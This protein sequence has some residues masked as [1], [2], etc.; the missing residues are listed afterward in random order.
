MRLIVFLLISGIFPLSLFSQSWVES[1][2]SPSDKKSSKN[3]YE[4][5]KEFNE[6]WKEYEL[7]RGYYYV[8]GE[9]RKAGGWKQFK[10]W[11]WFW[12]TRI[13]RKTG[14][15]PNINMLEKHRN[16]YINVKSKS[17][18]SNW[19]EM[20]PNSSDGGYAGIGRLNCVAFH[21]TDPNTFFV[22]AP[23]GGLWKT[24][25][26]GQSWEVLTDT[27]PVIGVSE[28][29]VPNDYDT[30][31]TLYIATGD[32][33]A[34]DNYS[35]GVL[36]STDDGITWEQTG[37]SFNVSDGARIT[38]LLIHPTE[39]NILYASTNGGIYKSVDGA[40]NW[41]KISL[42]AAFFDIEYKYNCEDT[43][44]F[45]ATADYWDESKIYKTKDAGTTW[46]EVFAFPNMVYR[47]EL[48][49]ARSDSSV[50]YALASTRAGGMDGIYKST[51]SGNSFT[52]VSNC[53]TAC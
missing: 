3:F 2:Y 48:D 42:T 9:K 18:E 47:V 12:E 1:F 46:D 41:D 53:E 35:I 24:T 7:D 19:V 49:V 13:D 51:D 20:G 40:Q 52:K 29:I 23:S 4:I 50:V 28:V 39:Q 36:K 38:R 34:G 32:R 30:S 44:L 43:V 17:D 27:L 37:L 6:Y 8:N 11:E 5:Q 25:N 26:G 31:K 45:A 14:S 21:P 16:F 10:R 15:F 22:G 33:D